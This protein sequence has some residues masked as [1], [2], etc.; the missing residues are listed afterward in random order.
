M[1][2]DFGMVFNSRR[3][4]SPKPPP[5]VH[6]DQKTERLGSQLVISSLQAFILKFIIKF[7]FILS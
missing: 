6:P 4:I 5:E 1:S 3:S 7:I 2:R